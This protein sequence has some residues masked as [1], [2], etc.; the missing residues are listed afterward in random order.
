MRTLAEI[1]TEL[2]KT[3]KITQKDLCK[4]IGI[5]QGYLGD[6]KKGRTV[7]SESSIQAIIDGLVLTK[8]EEHE[9]WKAWTYEKGHKKTMEYY[10]KLEDENRK[11]KKIL[12]EIKEI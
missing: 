9:V 8:E 11:L 2:L 7:G 6:I 5:A 3:R 4:K 12:K 10:F 1:I